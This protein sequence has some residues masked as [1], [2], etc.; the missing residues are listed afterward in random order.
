MNLLALVLS[1]ISAAWG[2]W[3]ATNHPIVDI[4][5]DS[6][7]DTISAWASAG[8]QTDGHCLLIVYS[9]FNIEAQFSESQTARTIN[10]E[11]GHCLGL[12]HTALA[13]DLMN[14]ISTMQAPGWHDLYLYHQTFKY[15]AVAAVVA[16]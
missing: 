12:G 3:G 6:S 7:P 2:L 13:I 9:P 16:R 4:R 1:L 10:H 8:V 14:P 5:F 15:R 11:M